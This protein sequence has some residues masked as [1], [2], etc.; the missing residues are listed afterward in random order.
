MRR[1]VE[2]CGECKPAARCANHEACATQL[3]AALASEIGAAWARFTRG[4][5]DARKRWPPFEGRVAEIAVRLVTGLAKGPRVHELARI[6]HWRAGLVWDA[7]ARP[8]S[9]DRPYYVSQGGDVV[10]PLLGALQIRFRTRRRASSSRFTA[11][12]VS[13][14]SSR[15]GRGR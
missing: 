6:C 13:F 5:L 7:I 8:G 12:D 15:R 2:R 14:S 10:F 1:N 9:R 11:K 3:D 4:Q